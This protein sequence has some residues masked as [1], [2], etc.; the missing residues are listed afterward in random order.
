[1]LTFTIFQ[2][3]ETHSYSPLMNE[4]LKLPKE[5]NKPLYD[6]NKILS[7][8]GLTKLEIKQEALNVVL[9]LIEMIIQDDVIDE[10]EIK[11]VRLLCVFLGIEEGD[12]RLYEKMDRVEHII[13]NQMEQLYADN[14]IDANEALYKS[15]LQG[16]LGLSYN[17]YQ[18][19]VNKVALKAYSK[20]AEIKD[21]DTYL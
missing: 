3:L 19:I 1:M 10:D 2:F 18:D 20:G 12:F 5:S 9:D 6:L 14:K 7:E 21:L 8:N 4:I 15:N 16:L 11:S 13:L 17:E